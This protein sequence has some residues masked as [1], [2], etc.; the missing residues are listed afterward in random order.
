MAAGTGARF[1]TRKQYEVLG[2]RRVLDWA[3]ATA[4][5]VS[6]GVVLVVPP[7]VASDHE[8]GPDV[9]VAGGLTRSGSVRAG[10]DA[11]PADADVVVVHDAARPLAPAWLFE[12]VVAAVSAGADGAVPGLPL[13]DTVKRVRDGVVEATLDRSELLA[14]QTPQA[15]RAEALRGAHAGGAEASDDA[16]LVEAAGGRVVVVSGDPVNTKITHAE[17]LSRARAYVGGS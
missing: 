9:V 10:L 6:D 3:V 15:F 11:I 1:G 2:T 13:A 4:R 16:A 8:D 5:A 14:I 7:E 12:S 17:D